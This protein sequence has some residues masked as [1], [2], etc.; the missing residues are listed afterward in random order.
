M[1]TPSPS[2]LYQQSRPGHPGRFCPRLKPK[3]RCSGFWCAGGPP[4]PTPMRLARC[5]ACACAFHGRGQDGAGRARRALLARASGATWMRRWRCAVPA[6]RFRSK[7]SRRCKT[8]HPT[9]QALEAPMARPAR[10]RAGRCGADR[11][12]RLGRRRPS[13]WWPPSRAFASTMRASA[14]C[15]AL[16]RR[17]DRT[18]KRWRR[19]GR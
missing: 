6:M 11:P 4:L 17:F 19:A 16:P 8:G 1:T 5:P 13:C 3:G 7:R 15:T 10:V 9:A 14:M 18:S 12:R 2:S